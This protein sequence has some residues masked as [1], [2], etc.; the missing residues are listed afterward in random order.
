MKRHRKTFTETIE[1]DEFDPGEAVEPVRGRTAMPPGRYV[2]TE[3]HHPMCAGDEPVA[4][5]EGYPFGV[6]ARH[7][8]AAGGGPE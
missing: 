8:R 4:F 6:D 2:V 7:L 1:Y 5:V 3:F